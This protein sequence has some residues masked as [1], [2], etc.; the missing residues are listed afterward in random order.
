[1]VQ[2]IVTQSSLGEVEQADVVVEGAGEGLDVRGFAG[3]WWAVEEVAAAV[4][5]AYA[6]L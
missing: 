6:S 4:W 3:T 5:N 2:L 1:M